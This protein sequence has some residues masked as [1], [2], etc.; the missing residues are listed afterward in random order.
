MGNGCHSFFL[1]AWEAGGGDRGRRTH[2]DTHASHSEG[3]GRE[4]A[5]QRGSEG[6]DR[7]IPKAALRL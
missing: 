5:K 3:R 1:K 6:R 2:T 4:Q 7:E